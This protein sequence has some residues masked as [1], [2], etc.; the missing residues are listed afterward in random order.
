M[1]AGTQRY[2]LV[3]Q[4]TIL[5]YGG[6]IWYYRWTN[7]LSQAW[8][9]A[10]L[11]YNCSRFRFRRLCSLAS[12]SRQGSD[13]WP[14]AVAPP[15]SGLTQ[16]LMFSLRFHY[17]PGQTQGLVFVVFQARASAR[18]EVFNTIVALFCED[19]LGGLRA[20]GYRNSYY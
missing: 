14:T 13:P 1:A 5:Y 7:H 2:D 3:L 10:V 17:D 15:R 6:T 4:S 8:P 18:V 19:P 11:L 20:P 16:G 9:H 12:H